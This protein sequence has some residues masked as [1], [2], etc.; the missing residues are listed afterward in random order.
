M[1]TPEPV[2]CP[3]CGISIRNKVDLEEKYCGRCHWWTLDPE[4][5]DIWRERWPE[6]A[7]EARAFRRDRTLHRLR[8]TDMLLSV[9]HPATCNGGNP[10]FTTHHDHEVVLEWN[11]NDDLQCPECGRVQSMA[12]FDQ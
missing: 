5:L 7:A 10:D 3:A 2:R 8:A 6:K 11:D 1:G 4:Q 12:Q 9:G